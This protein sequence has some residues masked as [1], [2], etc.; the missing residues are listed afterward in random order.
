M[1]RPTTGPSM[2]R[3]CQLALTVALEERGLSRSLQTLN[4]AKGVFAQLGNEALAG[5]RRPACRCRRRSGACGWDLGARLMEN[6]SGH[7]VYEH[8]VEA[9]VGNLSMVVIEL[10]KEAGP[11]VGKVMVK[12]D[13]AIFSVTA[14]GKCFFMSAW[15]L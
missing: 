15:R 4:R 2:L 3:P 10:V 8:D 7:A 14:L 6:C 9:V 5:T 11:P 12:D 13:S 1:N